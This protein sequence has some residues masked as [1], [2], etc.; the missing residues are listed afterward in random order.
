MTVMV[1]TCLTIIL[2]IS[3]KVCRDEFFHVTAAATN[4]FDSLGLKDILCS[5][6]H[7][8]GKHDN[9]THLSEHGS[10]SALATAS[11]R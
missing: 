3:C 11:F 4:H 9:H 2:D 5:L 7:I 8:T 10:Y 6:A 1:V